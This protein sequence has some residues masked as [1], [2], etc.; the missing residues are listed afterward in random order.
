MNGKM[1]SHYCGALRDSDIGEEVTLW[2][3]CTDAG[4]TAG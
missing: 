2:V 1:R 3:G 4:I